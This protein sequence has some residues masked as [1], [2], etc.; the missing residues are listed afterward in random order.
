MLRK[1][2]CAAVIAVLTIGVA[3]ADEFGAV[4]SKVDGDKVTFTKTRNGEKVGAAMTLPVSADAKVTNGKLDPNDPKKLTA[5][6]PIQNGLRN[7]V[8]A[9]IGDKGLM[10]QITTDADNKHIT[11]IT[12]P[13]KNGK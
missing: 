7:A 10:V 4:V 12:V 9:K 8:F 11:A 3:M 5:G 6:D 1:V 2:V 13:K